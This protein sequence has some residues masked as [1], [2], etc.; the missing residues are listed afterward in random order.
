MQRY[1]TIVSGCFHYNRFSRF[2]LPVIRNQRLQLSMFGGELGLR[3]DEDWAECKI[4]PRRWASGSKKIRSISLRLEIP[5]G[6]PMKE[7]P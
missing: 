6:S 1:S 3:R 4:F 7:R 5:D 2:S